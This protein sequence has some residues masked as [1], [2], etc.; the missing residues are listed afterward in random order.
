MRY[1]I[2]AAIGALLAVLLGIPSF[3]IDRE[4]NTEPPLFRV[5]CD[6]NKT[7]FWDFKCVPGVGTAA[8]I[9]TGAGL[10]AIGAA[11]FRRRTSRPSRTA[12][13]I[14]HTARKRTDSGSYAGLGSRIDDLVQEA[15]RDLARKIDN[16]N[17]KSINHSSVYQHI[18][19]SLRE[20]ARALGIGD[21]AKRA[22][23]T[24]IE[25]GT[26]RHE[27]GLTSRVSRTSRP[28]VSEVELA[29]SAT[30]SDHAP[31][32]QE[33]PARSSSD[34]ATPTGQASGTEPTTP[35]R[36]DELESLIRLNERG[37]LTD[38]ELEAARA[39]LLRG[40]GRDEGPRGDVL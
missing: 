7:D 1:G 33:D 13:E 12:T 20:R 3:T 24:A 18:D 29:A 8:I 35:E 14:T 10:G 2:G 34:A 21:L 6:L 23:D 19:R 15:A 30:S 26:L 11:A 22:L 40:P 5:Y 31:A 39:R 16:Y 4:A 32:P 36:P 25:D 27:T 37:I 38:A 28:L 9:L 17:Y